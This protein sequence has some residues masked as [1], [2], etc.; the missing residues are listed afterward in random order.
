[1]AEQ[2][3]SLHPES[4]G[5]RRVLARLEKKSGNLVEAE[6]LYREVVE[7]DPECVKSREVYAEVKKEFDQSEYGPLGPFYDPVTNKFLRRI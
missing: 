3:L 5:A 4:S 1:M 2:V 6:Q 7:Y